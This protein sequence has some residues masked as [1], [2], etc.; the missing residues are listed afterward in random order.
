MNRTQG[1]WSDRAVRG[2]PALRMAGFLVA[3]ILGLFPSSGRAVPVINA[4]GI[5]NAASYGLPGSAGPAAGS[6]VSLFGT[7]L[8]TSTL[9]AS[10]L[11]LPLTLGTTSVSVSGVPAPLFYVSPTQINFQLP[12]QGCCAEIVR[13]VTVTVNDI[14]SNELVITVSSFGPAL[15]SVNSTGSGQGA[16]Q[17]ANTNIFAAPTGSI[18]GAS[19]RPAQRGES[20]TIFAI[21]LGPVA[22]TPLAG[23]AALP[24]PLS[25]TLFNLTVSI[26]GIP[27][28][29]TFSGLAPGF[30]GLYQVNV[31]VPFSTS[32][33]NAVPVRISLSDSGS[34]NTVTMAVQ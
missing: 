26:G 11:P 30:V 10:T 29:V 33:G 16:I 8:A 5:V 1:K 21:G 34:S 31:R 12:W 28:D 4:G 9:T 24:S 22:P 7:G 17:I 3:G 32:T 25:E 14:S 13:I 20:I 2:R 6:I 19:S 23:T 15:F 18:A 27:A